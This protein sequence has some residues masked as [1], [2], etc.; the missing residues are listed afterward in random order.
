MPAARVVCELEGGFWEDVAAQHLGKAPKSAV[1]IL[2]RRVASSSS[3][4]AVEPS[5]REQVH[6][7]YVLNQK[8]CRGIE[9]TTLVSSLDNVAIQSSTLSET[10]HRFTISTRRGAHLEFLEEAAL[11][12]MS[13]D[14]ALDALHK[15]RTKEKTHIRCV[16]NMYT[17]C[18]QVLGIH[19]G[20][21]QLGKMDPLINSQRRV[22]GP[23]DERQ[24][25]TMPRECA[26]AAHCCVAYLLVVVAADRAFRR[27]C[28]AL[29]FVCCLLVAI[30][31]AAWESEHLPSCLL[32]RQSFLQACLFLFVILFP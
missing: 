30:S 21:T 19:A 15:C 10:A 14:P 2:N 25:R 22:K 13:A 8:E 11:S 18:A 9:R 6:G 3:R 4:E 17:A 24:Q 23:S 5:Y 20:V 12:R 26:C 28:H 27:R 31:S 32:C 1:D 29:A 7:L 16:S